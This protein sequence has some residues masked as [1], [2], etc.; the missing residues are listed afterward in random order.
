MRHF[1]AA[2]VVSLTLAAVACSDVVAPPTSTLSPNAPSL[3]KAAKVTVCHA[4]GRD[5]TTKYV[6]I[7]ISGNAGQ[8]PHIDDNGTTRAGH[9]DD[10]FQ[11]NESIPCGVGQLQVC[12]R[13]IG[14]N[15][16]GAP[17]FYPV[18]TFKVTT[19]S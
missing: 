13:L 2:A 18:Q 19:R 12:V 10:Y 3:A 1:L 4:A 11:T 15:T 9:E 6:S 17:E 14:D 7:T 16:G 5:G 8:N